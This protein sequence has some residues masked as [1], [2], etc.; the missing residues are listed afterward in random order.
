MLTDPTTW[1]QR[2][3]PLPPPFRYRYVLGDTTDLSDEQNDAY[4]AELI[5][6]GA[7]SCGLITGQ[8]MEGVKK[9]RLY[10]NSQ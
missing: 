2:V 4:L 6:I 7:T 10:R 1:M 8:G 3:I 9:S 5:K